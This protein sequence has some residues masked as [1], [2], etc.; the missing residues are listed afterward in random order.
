MKKLNFKALTLPFFVA[1]IVL[2]PFSTTAQGSDGFFR[3]NESENYQN[4]A[5]PT[6]DPSG[7][8]LGGATQMDPTAPLGSGL[9]VMVAA[10][11]GYVALKRRNSKKAR[12]SRV[13]FMSCIAALLVLL[14]LTNCK[15]KEIITS[16][17]TDGGI[18]ITLDATY[19]GD[20]TGF[21]PGEGTFVW[22]DGATEY[23]YVGGDH[24]GDN[25]N[26]YVMGVLSGTGNGKNN[27]TFSGTLTTPPSNGETLY[28]YYLGYE[29][30]ATSQLNNRCLADQDG[31]LA[32]VTKH[33]IA[34]GHDN[35]TTSKT[36]F[37]ATLNMAMSIAR[38]DLSG[39]GA[40][41]AEVRIYGE[42]VFSTCEV[43]YPNGQIVGKAR[44]SIKTTI[45]SGGN[46]IALIPS[47]QAK[48]TL[49][50]ISDTKEGSM[51]FEPGIQAGYYYAQSG[52]SALTVPEQAIVDRSEPAGKL[53]GVFTISGTGNT[54][55]KVQ[56][57]KGNL[58][59]IG[60]AAKPYWKFADNQYD[61][62]GTT[63][64]QN[65][66]NENVDRDL[67]GWGTSGYHNDNDYI[68]DNYYPYSTANNSS[69][70][71]TFPG[72]GPTYQAGS[73]TL[74][75]YDLLGTSKD[76]DWGI[77]NAI[78]YGNDYDKSDAPG[79]WRLLT[80]AEWAWMLGPYNET[81]DPGINCRT[82]A[83]VSGVGHARYAPANLPEG[84]HGFIVF[85]DDFTVPVDPNAN[86]SISI[87]RI[88]QGF[89]NS[90]W[91]EANDYTGDNAYKW[92]LLEQAGCV[93][94]PLAGLRSGISLSYDNS[95]GY[96]WTSIYHD[97]TQA[98]YEYFDYRGPYSYASKSLKQYRRNGSSVRLVHDIN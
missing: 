48:T 1:M 76:Y 83:T 86:E 31:T 23:I 20:K 69:A 30:I 19:G 85:P 84:T 65:S 60:S 70:S 5:M 11:A 35:Y 40:V 75:D 98:L 13:T 54:A 55:K 92:G 96:Y 56:F 71:S 53:S 52:G 91:D 88:N 59:Y 90:S 26:T 37:N 58:Q 97:K 36:K 67:F 44:G 46:Y 39:F 43:D 82:S 6:V 27:M 38:I 50:F 81:P 68:N 80:N 7:M 47:T 61:Y 10:G 94:L 57:S 17:N 25:P 3:A 41:G 18:F 28:F 72:Y 12:K 29:P 78:R 64:E 45:Q 74:D 66:A 32:N 2:L 21:N 8:T 24:H 33:H 22:T 9:L 49:R 63:T 89:K 15:K 73:Y 4:R 16:N 77:H 95:K 14:T 93:F 87:K 62:L 42:D 34:I 51:D 79:K